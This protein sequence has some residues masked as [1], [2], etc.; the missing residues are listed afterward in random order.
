ML[1]K[2]IHFQAVREPYI[3]PSGFLG[4]H[5]DVNSG[6]YFFNIDVRFILLCQCLQSE[7]SG[8]IQSIIINYYYVDV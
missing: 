5:A 7:G 6:V 1:C 4:C 8:K 3:M 2:G